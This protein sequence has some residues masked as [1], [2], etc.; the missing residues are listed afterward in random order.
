V[1]RPRAPR[2]TWID[3][4]APSARIRRFPTA[5]SLFRLALIVTA[6]LRLPAFRWDVISDD[7]AI[8]DTMGHDI[9]LGGVMYRTTVDHKPPGL[10]YTYAGARTISAATGAGGA[11]AMT[12]IHALGLLA[13]VGTAA[14]L[15]AIG[16]RIASAETGAIAA[17]LYGVVSAAKPMPDGLAVNGELLMNLPVALAMLAA[18]AAT[19][20]HRRGSRIGLDLLA[21]AAIGIA[22]LF[23]Y[24]AGLAGVAL[25]LLVLDRPSDRVRAL[26]ARGAC[27]AGGL[28]VPLAAAALY[29]AAHGAVPDLVFWGL[30]FN[31]NYLADGPSLL[32]AF[33][34]LGLQ[35]GGV[36]LPGLLLYGGALV[37]AIEIGRRLR[38]DPAD[39]GSSAFLL[40]WALTATAAVVL[41]ARFF[42]HYFLQAELPLALV[43]AIPVG[44][45][46][47]RRPRKTSTLLFAPAALFFAIGW[48]PSLA[49]RLFSSDDPDWRTIGRVAA[50]ATG[51]TE[52]IWVWGNVPQIYHAAD[53]RQ[54]VRFS[55][56]NY[57]TGLSPATPSEEDSTVD[58]TSH[59]VSGSMAMAIADL[60]R[61]RP[62]LLLDTA[63]HDVKHYGRFPLRRFPALGA[64]VDAH[65]RAGPTIGGVVF[66]RR[67]D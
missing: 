14:A 28:L 6:V 49:A 32:W 51:P 41:G 21:G 22:V 48:A 66:Y 2:S 44:R 59:A 19:G 26:V 61:N 64:Y 25:P 11:R 67:I 8:Y 60:D 46:A 37:G 55:F 42:G 47:R 39:R 62:A 29:F 50:A 23:K 17:L 16:R 40:V 56:C 63:P 20:S 4:R 5:R 31:R 57:L 38:R 53:R 43:A 24:Q 33:E 18:L 45:W 15:F 34:R 7:E 9:A 10:A 30:E 52:R 58:P 36:V 27:W 3:P 12:L 1:R 13:A 65:Y 54:G 35:L